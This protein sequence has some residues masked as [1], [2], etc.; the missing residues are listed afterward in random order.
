MEGHFAS[1]EAALQRREVYRALASGPE[2]VHGVIT[3]QA[4][5]LVE[6]TCKGAAEIDRAM[7]GHFASVEAALQRREVYRALASGPEGVHG[8]ITSQARC[9]VELTCK[10]AAE[11][12]ADQAVQCDAFWDTSRN[13]AAA[14]AH[15]RLQGVL[16]SREAQHL[17]SQAASER[18]WRNHSKRQMRRSGKSGDG[19][20]DPE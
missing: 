6:L 18:K 1:V 7:E 11:R 20:A 4:R 8:V 15:T 17:M 19:A 14:A 5:C 3:S 13:A 2:G 10:G 12:K 16:Q 9:L